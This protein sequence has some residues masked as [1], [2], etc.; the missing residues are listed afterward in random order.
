MSPAVS[1]LPGR[2]SFH[3]GV[4]PP[5]RKAFAADAA[6]EVVPTP[7]QVAIALLQHTGAPNESAV[8]NR[9]EVALGDVVGQTDAFVSAVP[10]DTTRC[11]AERA[12]RFA[13][14]RGSLRSSGAPPLNGS[15]LAIWSP[16]RSTAST[17][18]DSP[19]G[20]LALGTD[21]G[22][23]QSPCSRPSFRRAPTIPSTR[24][25]IAYDVDPREL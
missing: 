10:L 9:Q 20:P 2:L 14:T 24:L 3:R 18:F 13:P 21:T 8:K 1:A 15:K 5:Q 19:R 23:S 22:T 7:K 12:P 25:A 6:I 4:H 11:Y 17:L 16:S